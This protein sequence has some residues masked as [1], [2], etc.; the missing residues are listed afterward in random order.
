M[1]EM[2]LFMI[3]SG[4]QTG[5]DRGALDAA[6]D[7]GVPCGG[8]CPEGRKAEDGPIPERYP[9]QVLPGSGYRQRTRQNVRDSDATVIISF[10]PIIPGSGTDYTLRSCRAASKPHLLIDGATVPPDEAARLIFDFVIATGVERLNLAG[11]RAE[12]APQAH[13]YAQ[14]A[15]HAFL[16]AMLAAD[17]D[18]V[19]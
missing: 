13:G 7:L 10:G 8:W 2:A 5:V 15:I 6:L 9:L 1:T 3:I 19:P 11:P 18:G 17:A 16:C 14:A 12:A 4:G